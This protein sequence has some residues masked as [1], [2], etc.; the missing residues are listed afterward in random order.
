MNTSNSFSGFNNDESINLTKNSILKNSSSNLSNSNSNIRKSVSINEL[1]NVIEDVQYYNLDDYE[2]FNKRT[3]EDPENHLEKR[4]SLNTIIQNNELPNSRQSSFLELMKTSSTE[5]M[6]NLRESNNK[7]IDNNIDDEGDPFKVKENIQI[8][9]PETRIVKQVDPIS[10]FY[11]VPFHQPRI[12]IIFHNKIYPR[13]KEVM[14]IR[15]MNPLDCKTMWKITQCSSGTVNYDPEEKELHEFR[16]SFRELFSSFSFNKTS[17][18]VEPFEEQKILLTFSPSCPGE[19]N[20]QWYL[21]CKRTKVLLEITGNC[22]EKLQRIKRKPIMET[23]YYSS[24]D[25]YS[26]SEEEDIY[27]DLPYLPINIFKYDDF[28]DQLDNENS[29]DLNTKEVSLSTEDSDYF[30][31]YVKP[32]AL[33][34]RNNQIITDPNIINDRNIDIND[35]NPKS[36]DNKRNKKDKKRKHK[37][38]N[39][40]IIYDENDDD[41]NSTEIKSNDYSDRSFENNLNPKPGTSDNTD[42]NS[43]QSE[44]EIYDRNGDFDTDNINKPL[45][46]NPSEDYFNK[47]PSKKYPY[48]NF[49][50]NPNRNYPYNNYPNSNYPNNNPNNFFNPNNYINNNPYENPTKLPPNY[51]SNNDKDKNNREYM[52]PFFPLVKNIDNSNEM[53]CYYHDNNDEDKNN[54][55]NNSRNNLSN[56]NNINESTSS[57][58]NSKDSMED[59]N[60]KIDDPKSKKKNDNDPSNEGKRKETIKNHNEQEKN[61]KKDKKKRHSDKNKRN[62]NKKEIK[63]IKKTKKINIKHKRKPKNKKNEYSSSSSPSLSTRSIDDIDSDI[64]S[65]YSNNNSDKDSLDSSSSTNSEENSSSKSPS[66]SF[67]SYSSENEIFYERS[68]RAN[69]NDY[70]NISNN[71]SEIYSIEYS[72]DCMISFEKTSYIN[73]ENCDIT[74]ERLKNIP[75]DTSL[76]TESQKSQSKTSSTNDSSLSNEFSSNFAQAMIKSN[77]MNSLNCHPALSSVTS[78]TYSS[79]SLKNIKIRNYK[80]YN[81]SSN[82]SK[83]NDK[84]INA[85]NYYNNSNN[86]DNDENQCNTHQIPIN[87]NSNKNKNNSYSNFLH[88]DTNSYS[89]NKS[90]EQDIFNLV[91]D[92]YYHQFIHISRNSDFSA[93]YS[94]NSSFNSFKNNRINIG[95]KNI[96]ISEIHNKM[97]HRY[98]NNNKSSDKR[99]NICDEIKKTIQTVYHEDPDEKPVKYQRN[100]EVK[101]MNYSNND[102]ENI[103]F[104]PKNRIKIYNNN[105]INDNTH[106]KSYSETS[107][108]NKYDYSISASINNYSNSANNNYHSSDDH[109]YKKNNYSTSRYKNNNKLNDKN[110]YN[111]DTRYSV[112]QSYSTNS[113]RCNRSD[114]ASDTSIDVLLQSQNEGKIQQFIT[115]KLNQMLNR[116]YK[117]KVKYTNINNNSIDI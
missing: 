1:N 103:L 29:N 75:T 44:I 15:L 19:Y 102:K 55:P 74:S 67:S 47:F 33:E 65:T 6:E 24:N 3:N 71:S 42:K 90:S 63:I 83:L 49:P 97:K 94:D 8:I 28:N 46:D 76:I 43:S 112:S 95:D 62:N 34:E 69:D 82:N 70:D 14:I 11:K 45:L 85:N 53:P 68:L 35:N 58:N 96:E 27:S 84:S 40:G 93:P 109:G 86:I 36:I 79:D 111:G 38:K 32:E 2:R 72:N 106:K 20:Q 48:N 78:N 88:Q 114:F 61:K 91:K 9:L 56:K 59:R 104:N 31:N 26:T 87:E 30:K 37:K 39:K 22:K 66:L 16:Y 92:P 13:K 25:S 60:L 52:N 98:T 100:W 110:S 12:P 57:L 54:L 51:N 117:R 7:N 89:Q 101:N 73:N 10:K 5:S 107:T 81:K 23:K 80:K 21:Q 50:N 77:S 108:N 116:D 4:H 113:N 17:G 105:I 18:V 64:S 115:S 41:M 99:N